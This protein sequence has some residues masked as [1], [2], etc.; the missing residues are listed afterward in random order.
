MWNCTRLCDATWASGN[1][2]PK[3]NE[4]EFQYNDGYFLTAANLFA[5]NHFPTDTKWL[6]IANNKLTFQ[7]FINTP[8]VYSGTFTELKSYDSPKKFHQEI[9]IYQPVKKSIL[10]HGVY[11]VIDNGDYSKKTEPSTR[12]QEQNKLEFSYQFTKIG[13]YDVHVFI[14]NKLIATHTFNVSNRV[15]ALNY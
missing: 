8:I 3:T 9:L 2:N 11:L 12:K 1:A 7:E 10:T 14:K 13:F 6:L 5:L 4:F 15:A